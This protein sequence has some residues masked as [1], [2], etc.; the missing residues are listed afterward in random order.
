MLNISI[1]NFFNIFKIITFIVIH[2]LY[3][4]LITLFWTKDLVLTLF[5]K[6]SNRQ[7]QI[8]IRF[9]MALDNIFNVYFS[10]FQKRQ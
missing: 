1:K 3:Q 10:I 2:F 5:S 4:N 7:I 8:R 9:G 6:I